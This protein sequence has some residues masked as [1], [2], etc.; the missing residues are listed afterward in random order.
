MVLPF[1][2][3]GMGRVLPRK[4]RV[5]RC[6]QAINVSVGSPLDLK[7]LT[8][9]CDGPQDTLPKVGLHRQRKS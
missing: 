7:D 1:Y 3:S 6:G 8:C 9:H 5:P 2:H 4:A